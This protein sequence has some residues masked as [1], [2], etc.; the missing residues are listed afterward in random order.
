MRKIILGAGISLALLWGVADA[1]R[2]NPLDTIAQ[3]CKSSGDC[4]VGVET[5]DGSSNVFFAWTTPTRSW[6][7]R[8][9][10]ND[11]LVVRDATANEVRMSFKTDGTINLKSLSGSY[12]GGQASVCVN[13]NGDLVA[14]DG[15]CS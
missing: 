15:A 4:K 9:G 2:L 14:V 8:L 11:K 1:M 10:A 7:I 12:G 3:Y 5:T 13:D 6:M